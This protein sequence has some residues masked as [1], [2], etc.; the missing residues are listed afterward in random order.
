MRDLS[1]FFVENSSYIRVKGLVLTKWIAMV[2]RGSWKM[3]LSFSRVLW[4]RK[5]IFLLRSENPARATLVVY[6]YNEAALITP[7][8]LL[9]SVPH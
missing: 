3:I 2:V 9:D 1:K 8:N 7:S 6:F 5:T 4:C